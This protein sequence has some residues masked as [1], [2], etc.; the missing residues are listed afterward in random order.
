MV[1]NSYNQTAVSIS[2]FLMVPMFIADFFF[3]FFKVFCGNRPF[4]ISAFSSPTFD[5]LKAVDRTLFVFI[6]GYKVPFDVIQSELCVSLR[7]PG[8]QRIYMTALRDGSPQ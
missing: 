7:L 3:F 5:R 2:T 4:F 6:S 8:F 1:R